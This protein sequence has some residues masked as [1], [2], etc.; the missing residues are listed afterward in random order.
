MLSGVLGFRRTELTTLLGLALPLVL[1]QLAQNGMSFVDTVMVGRLGPSSLAGLALGAT[2]FSSVLVV[3][4]AV[5]LAV[6]PLV[7]QAV[8]AK[9]RGEAGRVAGQ[10][11][12]LAAALSVPGLLFF[13]N[14]TPLLEALGTAPATVDLA[15]GYLRAVGFGFPF[16]LGFVALRGFLEGHGHARPIMY[17]A[18]VGVGLNVFL[19]DALIF[20]HYGLPQ[21]GMV[22]SGYATAVVYFVLFATGAALVGVGYR[23]ERIFAALRR[24]DLKVVGELVRLG[25]PISVTLGFEIGLFSVAT[26]LMGRF[27]DA[28]LA[29]H[30]IALQSTSTAFMVP[31]GVSI[32]T[33]VLVGQ[34]AG[35]GDR[36]GA[37]R[38]GVM[39]IALGTS[40]MVVTALVFWL[41]P[42]LV[43]GLYVNL[44]DPVNAAVI[45][46]AGTFLLIAG[47]FQVV[48][49]LQV[50][51]QGALR[52]LKDT[53]VPMLLTLVAYW[54]VGLPVG[55][56][57]A[58]TFGLGPRGLWFGMVAGLFTAAVLL[59]LRFVR[60][61]RSAPLGQ[62]I[63]Q[64]ESPAE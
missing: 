56:L 50:T 28:A 43:M 45:A 60:S 11:L 14:V 36:D 7:A 30:Q 21:L 16:A 1:A 61:A 54:L 17:I 37:R 9:R 48:D 8:G 44:N 15:S 55:L 59:S 32:A 33:S 26:L 52:G 64:W 63:T 5:I 25:W 19:N 6:A 41:A 42:R 39:G 35:R 53:R 46:Y 20:G 31:L 49:G 51:A 3:S 10:A 29:G 34:A 47:M 38:M 40:F 62:V 2:L 18:I 57:L 12:W 27:G 4:M 58:F 24:L 13:Y 23:Q 22:G